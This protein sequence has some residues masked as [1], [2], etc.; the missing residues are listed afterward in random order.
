[1]Y[2]GANSTNWTSKK[3]DNFMYTIDIN[4]NN[5]FNIYIYITLN[6]LL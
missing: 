6:E 4:I 3:C 1:M 2:N 5:I